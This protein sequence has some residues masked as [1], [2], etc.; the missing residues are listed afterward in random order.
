[1]DEDDAVNAEAVSDPLIVHD[2]SQLNHDG[3]SPS[4]GDSTLEIDADSDESA[5]TKPNFFVWSLTLSAGL[6]G[7]LFGYE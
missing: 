7:L 1:M 4:D 2:G 3:W 6:S 5:L